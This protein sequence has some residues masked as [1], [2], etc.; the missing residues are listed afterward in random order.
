MLLQIE[1]IDLVAGSLENAIASVGGFCCGK[2]FVI[3]HQVRID[4]QC[5]EMRSADRVWNLE[6]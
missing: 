3:D 1:E 6:F 2:A 5:L 4:F